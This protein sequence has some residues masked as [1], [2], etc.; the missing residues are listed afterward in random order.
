MCSQDSQVFGSARASQ[1]ANE[2]TQ[3]MRGH[4]K[5]VENSGY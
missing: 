2:D 1:T 4:G 3:R 5:K